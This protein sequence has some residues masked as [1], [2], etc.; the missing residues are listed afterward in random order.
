[1]VQHR[2]F[3]VKRKVISRPMKYQLDGHPR[4]T[5]GNGV[6]EFSLTD[7]EHGILH[8]AIERGWICTTGRSSDR[9]VLSA[10]WL[11]CQAEQRPWVMVTQRRSKVWQCD[12]DM[13]TTDYNL[14]ER[15]LGL[16]ENLFRQTLRKR[17][18]RGR[19]IADVGNW[20]VCNCIPVEQIEYVA[21]ALLDIGS[22]ERVSIY[23]DLLDLTHS[24]RS[25]G[26]S[27]E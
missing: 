27:R 4:A 22:T 1:M 16:V 21:S 13:Y 2:K 9:L 19:M 11:W 25:S 3:E 17:K 7:R 20:S 14:S 26:D 12:L 8:Q 5:V 10:Y 6:I 15:G 18:R 24:V 23:P